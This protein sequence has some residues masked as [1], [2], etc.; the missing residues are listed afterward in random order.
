MTTTTEV[1]N[2]DEL[3]R[4]AELHHEQYMRTLRSLQDAI[5]PRRRER[6]DSRATGPEPFTPPMRALSGPMFITDSQPS[7]LPMLRRAR[8]STLEGLDRPSFTSEPPQLSSSPNSHNGV[9]VQDEY[10]PL[11]E[12]PTTVHPTEHAPATAHHILTPMHF[13][14]GMLLR[15]LKETEFSVEIKSLLED[16]LKRR[17]EIDMAV[18]FR[19]FAAYER[20]DY[21]VTSTFEVYE[22]GRDAIATKLSDDMDLQPE[23]KYSGDLGFEGPDGIVDAP[24]VWE[25]IKDINSNAQSVGRITLGASHPCYVTMH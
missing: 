13:D 10:I 2:V 20:E 18:P 21:H 25:A 5:A 17:D 23:I 22:V 8:R 19:D 6:S 1:Q 14:D 4:A 12:L 15:Y 24:T 7:S 16:V 9:V 11:L 3:I